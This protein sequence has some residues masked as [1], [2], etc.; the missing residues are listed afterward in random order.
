MT[1]K[2]LIRPLTAWLDDGQSHIR[3]SATDW[4]VLWQVEPFLGIK[5]SAK[6]GSLPPPVP[7]KPKSWTCSGRRLWVLLAGVAF[8]LV[9]S[10]RHGADFV[11]D[12]DSNSARCQHHMAK[13]PP[14][15][16][17]CKSL[18]IWFE[19]DR[20]NILTRSMAF[21]N[22]VIRVHAWPAKRRYWAPQTR[23]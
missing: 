7:K 8:F 16:W 22:S 20:A 5:R 11:R 4:L 19:A 3:S 21:C 1:L 2:N 13:L 14:V 6:P 9:C 15:H 10:R 18:Y 17:K 12:T 23:V